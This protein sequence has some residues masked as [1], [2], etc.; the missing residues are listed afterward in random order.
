MRHAISPSS[1]A[2]SPRIVTERSADNLAEMQSYI[3]PRFRS[4]TPSSPEL[5]RDTVLEELRMISSTRNM[6]DDRGVSRANH[7]RLELHEIV[8]KRG[9]RDRPCLRTR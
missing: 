1:S 2:R 9:E 5:F 7:V 3:L 4:E 6:E 8:A